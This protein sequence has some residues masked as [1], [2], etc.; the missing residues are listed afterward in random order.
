MKYEL[1]ERA[2]GHQFTDPMLI[3]LAMT[4][5]S[6]ALAHK[7]QDNQRLEFLG[8][9]VL[10]ICV[11]RVLYHRFP[12]LR[13]GQ[14]TRRRAALVCEANLARA[15][16]QLGLG[17]FLKLDRGEEI[18]GGRENPSILADTMEAVIAA[19]YLDAG[20]EKAAALIDM[21]MVDYESSVRADR[22]AKSALQEYLQ[23]LG[24]ETPTYEII[25][26]DGPPHARIFTARV[27]RADGTQLGTGRGAR[28]QR[29]EE[30]AAQ[31]AMDSLKK[32]K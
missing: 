18:V 30:A 23:A 4:H 25:G 6:F 22:D 5:P 16:R 28:K 19:V 29:A 15:G 2:I 21:I 10:E 31:M 27:L 24:E 20:M 3:D 12:K 14:L 8:D 7:C 9:A 1:L 32:T 26:E 17:A 13:E 11:S